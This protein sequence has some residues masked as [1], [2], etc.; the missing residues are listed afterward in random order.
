MPFT[1]TPAKENREGMAPSGLR[2]GTLA[3]AAHTA[4]KGVMLLSG[5]ARSRC[6][7]P[8]LRDGLEDADAFVTQWEFVPGTDD[9]ST[10][11][12]STDPAVDED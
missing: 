1:V 2:V 11:P 10:P 8:L 9:P 4:P 5:I 6:G 7:H 12:G 3:H